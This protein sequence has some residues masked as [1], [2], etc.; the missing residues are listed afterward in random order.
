MADHPDLQGLYH[1]AAEPIT[2]YDLLSL[3][4][5]V[6]G[7]AIQIEPEDEFVC[8]RT[9]NGSRFSETTGI[10]APSWREMIEQMHADPTPYEEFRGLNPEA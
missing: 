7:L 10:A 5:D 2:K 1:V 3:V 8:D 6:Y 9:L 4:R